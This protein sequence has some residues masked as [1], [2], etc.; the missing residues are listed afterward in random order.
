MSSQ[1]QTLLRVQTNV[2]S[3][4]LSGATTYEYLDL[5]DDVPIKINKSFAE[6][7]D[8]SK[9]N[10][11]FS[12]NLSLPGSKT[13]NRFFES[14][15]N[16]DADSLYFFSN[17]KT[18]C[19]VLINEESF[20]NG[21]MRLNKVNVLDSKVEYDVTLFS[22]IANL[23]GDIGNK[24]LKDLDFSDPEYTFNHTFD[25]LNT[26]TLFQDQATNFGLNREAP[27][28]YFYP[29]VHNGYEY[30]GST[31]NLSGGTT[32]EQTRFYTSTG[33]ISGWTTE[34]AM[35]AA[36]VQHFRINT[37]GEGIYDNQL[38][39]ALSMW[40]LLKLIFKTYGYS[41]TSD[42]M[43]T[44]WMKTLYMYGYFSSSA[45]KFSYNLQ[46]IE[47][48]PREGVE[49]IYSGSTTP[50]SQLLIIICKRGTG[51]PVYCSETI[52]YG[53]ANMF[54]YSEYGSIP[55]GVSGATITAVEGFDFGFPVDGVPVADI[56]T[57][58]YLPKAVGSPV[59]FQ[60]G[61][62]VNFNLVVDQNIKQIDII[63]SIAKKFNLVFIPNP[64]NPRDIIIEPYSYYIGT[65]VVHDWTSKLSYDKGFSVE[66]AL[67]YI[68]SNLIFTDLE[69]GDYGNKE[70]KDREK[71]VYGTQLF[72]GP[73]DFK[74][75]TGVTETI[76]SPEVLRQWDTRDQPNNG[77][78][79]LPL[80]INYV[81]SSTTEEVGGNSQT[82]YAYKGLKTKPKIFWFLGCNNLFLDTLG[83]VYPTSVYNT[84][85]INVRNSS[86][87]FGYAL[88]TAPIISHTMPMGMSDA[89][90]INNDS[91]C[92]LFSSEFPVDIGVQTY[93]VY[94]EN[95]AYN[96]FYENRISNLYDVNTRFVSGFFDLKYSDI[97]NLEPK[98]IIKIQEQYF[99]V[100]KISEYNLVNPELTRVELVQT[101]LNPQTY[102]TRY[103]KYQYCDQTGYT[104]A[105]ATDFTNPNLRDTSFGWSIWYDQMIGILGNTYSGVTSSLRNLR[106]G[107]PYYIPFT[108]NEISE[109]EY[110]N[111]GYINWTGDTMLEEVWNYV[112]P[113]FPNQSYAFGL[114]LPAFWNSNDG[115]YDG[116]NLF[117]GCTQFN[118]YASAYNIL[119]GSSQHY[120][121]PLT[122]SCF[123]YYT[124]FQTSA[125]LTGIIREVLIND[126]FS[127]YVAGNFAKY[128]GVANSPNFG[129]TFTN[130]IKLKYDGSID[131]SFT[132]YG[133]GPIT[134]N[135]LAAVYVIKKQSTGKLI[136]A[137]GL[138][139]YSGNTTGPILRL[140][141]NGT[142][143]TTYNS[144]TTITG[145]T[146]QDI[147]VLSDDKI[148][149]GGGFGYF[150]PTNVQYLVKLN[151]NGTLDTSFSNFSVNDTVYDVEVYGEQLA[152]ALR[153]RIVICGEFTAVGFN[154]RNRIAVLNS[155]GTT[156][157]T[158]NPGSGFPS[159]TTVS[160]VE[161][162][163]DGKI[164]VGGNFTS[165]NGTTGLQGLCRL[166]YD[167]TL[168]TTFQTNFTGG[169]LYQPVRPKYLQTGQILVP[170]SITIGGVNFHY[171]YRL[172]NN[173]SIDT[174]FNTSTFSGPNNFST[175]GATAVQEDGTIYFGGNFQT[176]NGRNLWSIVKL[177]P[178]GYFV[179]CPEEPPVD[180]PNTPTLQPLNLD[181]RTV[182]LTLTKTPFYDTLLPDPSYVQINGARTSE[183]NKLYQ[184]T[185]NNTTNI[186]VL[187]VIGPTAGTRRATINIYQKYYTQ[188]EEN[189]DKGIV[190][191]L[192]YT[193]STLQFIAPYGLG[194]FAINIPIPDATPPLP[195]APA[196][197]TVYSLEFDVEVSYYTV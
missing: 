65:G 10:T 84:Y 63:S 183:I 22:S 60:E 72:Y 25:L 46:T 196:R 26:I 54:P 86:N 134:G 95:D 23:F 76:F 62:E 48:L 34:A 39:P 111:S 184:Y 181:T 75:Q 70:F 110:Q 42:F 190:R 132:N 186:T 7:Q 45:T 143:D 50:G 155:D 49:L 185:F 193:N 52:N 178:D 31:I 57:L 112:N 108:M 152:G 170:V 47:Y 92:I 121:P 169:T 40:G 179:E 44:P 165:Y 141:T 188:D 135:T 105:I 82:F 61:D 79:K 101:N 78:I 13:N 127:T 27:F 125:N 114:G 93:N 73:T 161:I 130:M 77:G 100:N 156:F 9:K 182:N 51:V 194:T 59:I 120:G 32:N 97:I 146:V 180:L 153:G 131:T 83:E 172:N 137:G 33:P 133:F 123:N 37:R 8:I 71:Q 118:S 30:T 174:S 145:G 187:A 160:N 35:F 167:G 140:N 99:Y 159:G 20:F 4:T 85:N 117:T 103:F 55:T 119:T 197:N 24:L 15:Y 163:E 90:K 142:L 67:N 14:F 149:I 36:G 122:G 58:K 189:G 192:I 19:D 28:M 3:L 66:P 81:G 29:I 139:S 6:L 91:A 138:T 109:S 176:Y 53:F 148:I 166:N 129:N 124:H 87:S 126:D 74:S 11:D 106:T 175:E 94:T 102:P 154:S 168:D 89:D 96:L 151:S 115:E 2:P 171:F 128:N 21:Y 69:D 191:E 147:Q 157:T 5:Y 116:L 43:N 107:V 1:Q 113:L 17:R 88:L 173:G 158:F 64:D 18:P 136:V 38:K 177:S 41:I 68:E 164:I 104:F 195:P 150:N 12:V 144:S 16:V 98:D 162:Q 80:G 56:S